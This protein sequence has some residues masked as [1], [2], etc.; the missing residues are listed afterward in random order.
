MASS[1]SSFGVENCNLLDLTKEALLNSN[2]GEGHLSSAT[3]QSVLL[4]LAVVLITFVTSAATRNYS[5][6]DK[7]WSI[8]PFLYTWILVCDS[9]TFLMALV[10]T[11][12]GFRL[13]WNFN[14]RGGYKWPPWDGDED[15]RWK[16]IQDGF[17]IK[18]L[19]NK[20]VWAL[21]N[22]GFIS[23]FQNV[24]LLLIAAPSIVANLVATS[25]G[26]SPLNAYDYVAAF[27]VV[28]FVI[29]ESVADNQ[30]YAFQTKKY[31]LRDDAASSE[32]L[33]LEG[34][35]ADGFTQSGLFAIVRK[36]N[37]AAEQAIWI[38]FYLFSIG[39]LQG[40]RYLNW[41]I[42]GC[43]LLCMLFTTS[44]WFTEKISLA[45]YPKYREYKNTVPMFVPNSFLPVKK[46]EE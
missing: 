45:K 18:M 20:I 27:S 37:Y 25:C 4:C 21:F 5:Q 34:E 23:L 26:E 16:Y 10:A 44:G 30:Q 33:P 7:L 13:T 22:F 46:K 31:K 28:L 8:V 15:Y 24:L 6:V 3:K 9:R 29:L 41:S 11:I 39:S 40:E 42:I 36:P 17:F 43:I 1:L 12:W 14:R 2:N 35:Y 32:K 38:S 19:Q